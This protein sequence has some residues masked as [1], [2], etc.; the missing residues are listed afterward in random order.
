MMEII[1]ALFTYLGIFALPLV[2]FVV[3]GYIIFA[4]LIWI[5]MITPFAIFIN[6]CVYKFDWREACDMELGTNLRK[7][8]NCKRVK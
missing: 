3:L 4:L 7:F 6:L 2:P 8:N 1:S 5:L